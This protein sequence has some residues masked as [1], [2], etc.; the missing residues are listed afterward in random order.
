[1]LLGTLFGLLAGTASAQ[2][3]ARTIFYFLWRGT[4]AGDARKSNS[5]LSLWDD[6]DFAPVRASL[7]NAW[8]SDAKN[9]KEKAGL[10]PEE[11]ASYATLLD[12]PFTIGY[13]PREGAPPKVAATKANASNATTPPWNGMFLVYDRSGKEDLLSKAVVRMRANSNEI[14]TLTEITFAGVKALKVERKSGTNYW[15]ETGKYAVSASEPAVFEEILK[16][17]TG[18]ATGAA[19]ADSDAYREAKPVLSGGLVEFFLRVPQIKNI[20][21]DAESASPQMKMLWNNFHLDAVHVFAGLIA[22]DGARTRLQG[23][24]LGDI[25]E[26]NLFDIWSTGQTQPSSLSLLTPDVIYYHESQISLL[27]IYNTLK[28][29]LAQPGSSTAG[30]ASTVESSV[31]TRIGMSLPDA[32]ALTSGE[33]G[34]LQTSPSL[35]ADKRVFFLGIS[36]KPDA[37]KLL[38]TIFSDQITSERN[39]GNVTYL[40]ISLKG[41]QGAKGVAQWNFYHLAMT[42]NLLLGASKNETLH[43]SVAQAGAPGAS[44]LPK[45]L[46]TARSQFPEKLNGFSYFDLQK[47]DWPA[48]QQQWASQAANT[49]AAAKTPEATQKARQWNDWLLSVN[50]AVFPRHLHSM[51]GASWK[52]SSGVHFDE[53]VD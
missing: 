29:L 18:K 1:L 37:L 3:P 42:P 21:G 12:N 7:A 34:S 28:R 24:V 40:K 2:L 22:L 31:Q 52:D 49:A 30:L 32:F 13:L 11:M 19:L 23:A 39:E 38:R 51:T 47:L 35:D 9:E 15:A 4:P 27:G 16:R 25:S 26:G 36:N 50:P 14:P 5:L 48:V 17:L 44:T 6:P 43:A 33:F 46:Q 41:S 45:N 10:S 8:M 20:A 53:W